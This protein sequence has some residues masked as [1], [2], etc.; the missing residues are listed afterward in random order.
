LLDVFPE[1][2]ASP[3]NSGNHIETPNTVRQPQNDLQR[4]KKVV[5][6]DGDRKFIHG[7]E[8]KITGE[9][10]KFKTSSQPRQPQMNQSKDVI[11]ISG[12]DSTIILKNLTVVGSKNTYE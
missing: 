3:H 4:N 9:I 2:E 12:N 7:E 6:I 10:N 11:G 1:D 5:G 8:F